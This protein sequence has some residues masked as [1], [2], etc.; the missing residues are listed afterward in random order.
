MQ[1]EESYRDMKSSRFGLGFNQSKSYKIKRIAMLMLIGI[2]A[3][4]VAILIG[5]A[6]EQAGFARHFQAN[7]IKVRRVLSFHYLGLRMI[8]QK[9]LAL[10]RQHFVAGVRHLKNMM[11]EAENGLNKFS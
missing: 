2:L 4:I 5:V 3:G 11:A 10:T 8:A 7:T 6:A 9:R 1:I